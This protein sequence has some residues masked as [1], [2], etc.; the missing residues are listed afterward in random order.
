MKKHLLEGVR[1]GAFNEEEA[2]KRFD[3]WMED[4]NKKISEKSQN[5]LKSIEEKIGAYV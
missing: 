2:D 5:I 3:N 4:K 1:K